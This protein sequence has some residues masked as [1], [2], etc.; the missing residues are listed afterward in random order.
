MKLVILC[1][2]NDSKLV[3][4]MKG[5][6]ADGEARERLIIWIRKRMEEFGI[7]VEAIAASMR[8]EAAHPPLY[9]NAR[10]EEWN[11]AGDMPDWLI[12]AKNAGVSPDFFRI[13]HPVELRV[14]SSS[15]KADHPQLDLFA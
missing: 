15:S 2:F 1:E 11:G 5:K 14:T 7:T 13:E 10:G 9:R 6:I 3:T 8:E 4:S 12:A